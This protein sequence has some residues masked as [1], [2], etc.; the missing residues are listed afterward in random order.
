M[1]LEEKIK[2][3]KQV[4][5]TLDREI[6]LFQGWSGLHCP[7][8]C[9]KCCF[10]PDIEATILEFLPF[11]FHLHK[12]GFAMDWLERLQTTDS[13]VCF[14]LNPTQ[15]GQGL[16][17]EYKHRGLICRL[18]GYSARTNKYGKKE[19]VTCEIIKQ[20]E[21]F[22]GTSDKIEAGRKEIPVLNQYYMQLHAIDIDLT[23]DF[24]PINIAIRKAIET[25][26]HY[27]TY[28]TES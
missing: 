7:A 22:A 15:A 10:K 4:F 5:E 13:S 23:R 24:Y 21:Q 11:A 18:F 1:S 6:A 19:L 8:G 2:A 20:E 28:R 9:G 14:I 12:R 3:V 26:M 25:V 16:C 17:S 27:Y